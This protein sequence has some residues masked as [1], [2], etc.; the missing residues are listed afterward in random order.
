NLAPLVTWGTSPEQVVA[1]TGRVPR[2]E[3]FADARKRN[4]AARALAYMGLA[5]GE[6]MTDIAID[7]VFVGSCTNARIEDLRAAARVV[8]GKSVHARVRAMIVPG[9]GAVKAQ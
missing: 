8:G 2:A 9:S 6:R 3:E 5:G 4:A 1:I 7:R